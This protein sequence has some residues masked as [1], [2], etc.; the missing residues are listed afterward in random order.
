MKQRFSF[1]V[2]FRLAWR[3]IWRQKKRSLMILSSAAVGMIG[4]LFTM[5]FLN[6]ILNGMIQSGIDSG[7]GYIQIR[8]SGYAEKRK[9]GMFLEKPFEIENKVKNAHLP[10]GVSFSLRMEREAM[11]K[12]DNKSQGVMVLGVEPETELGVSSFHEWLKGGT[13]LTDVSE[14]ERELGIIPCLIGEYNLKKFEIEV[15]D[16]LILTI[17]DQMGSSSSV[18]VKVTGYFQSPAEPIDKF[19]VLV[20]RKDL[21]NL[22][23]G[24]SDRVSYLVFG[25]EN[26]KIESKVLQILKQTLTE[27][28]VAVMG[29]D[30]ME[31]AISR[32]IEMYDQFSYIFYLILMLGFG[33]ILFDTVFMSVI[34]RTYEI[35]ILRSI[36][37]P[38]GFVFSM[39][40]LEA[41]FLTLIGVFIGGVLS[42]GIIFYYEYHGISLS[43][44]AKG[45]ELMAKSASTI[46]PSLDIKN[47]VNALI[48]SVIASFFAGFFP[49]WKSI[50]IKPVKALLHQ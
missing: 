45:M 44:F 18:R 19:S 22:F 20:K 14:R 34:E 4:I 50:R 25:L 5:G 24:K 33:L 11:L 1:A 36:G 35:G 38:S 10:A 31:P 43:F 17:S 27:F 30:E 47:F 28:Q 12:L 49:A 3:N 2:L 46:Y 37:T 32:M 13:F 21:S 41:F 42:S 39:V 40:L 48:L 26:Q 6:G 8:P 29:Y 15:G 16:F 7:L 23:S 9:N